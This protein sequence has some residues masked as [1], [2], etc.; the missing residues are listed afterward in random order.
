M[1]EKKS[2]EPDPAKNPFLEPARGG[3]A[4]LVG[5]DVRHLPG[6]RFPGKG[7]HRRHVYLVTTAGCQGAARLLGPRLLK[8]CG[9][10]VGEPKRKSGRR[11]VLA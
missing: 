6:E 9:T 7:V 3:E 4:P 5:T 1:E 10:R 8:K 2:P 11:N